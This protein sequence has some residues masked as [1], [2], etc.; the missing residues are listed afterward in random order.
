MLLGIA[1][2]LRS[3]HAQSDAS[4][5]PLEVSDDGRHLVQPDG[6]PVSVWLGT[7][8]GDEA[9]VHWF[10]PRTGESEAIG[11]FAATGK[12]TFAPP[13]DTGRGHDWGL[14]VDAAAA[15]F[16]PPGQLE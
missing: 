11:T 3:S 12:R 8:S 4:L 13:E 9:V 5:P 15:D 14:V 2:P 10:N 7:I 1:L 16:A 6:T